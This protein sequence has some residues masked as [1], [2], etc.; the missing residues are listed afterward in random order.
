MDNG[1]PYMHNTLDLTVRNSK[2]KIIITKLDE[3]KKSMY[4]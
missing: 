1:L 3:N 2:I 4:S